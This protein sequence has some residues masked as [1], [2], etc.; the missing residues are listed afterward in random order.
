[1]NIDFFGY[2]QPSSLG[3]CL[4]VYM[5]PLTDE[6]Q[7]LWENGLPTFDKYGQ[8]LF[9]MK[10]AVIWTISD[11]L[12]YEMLS[13]QQT[14]GYKACPI[15]LDDI[16][17]SR[18]ADKIYFLRSRRWLDEDHEWRWDAEAFDGTEEHNLKPLRRSGE[19]ILER[20]NQ[21]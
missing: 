21:H 11:F 16:N 4:D 19:W 12:A 3:K 15:C 18:H 6:L 13:G 5:R 8:T 9:M 20:L 1:M 2:Q 17:S 10:A 7:D 14:M